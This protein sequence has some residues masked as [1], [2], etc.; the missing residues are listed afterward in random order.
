MFRNVES[1][2]SVDFLSNRESGGFFLIGDFRWMTWGWREQEKKSKEGMEREEVLEIVEVI[3]DGF[4]NENVKIWKNVVA[5]ICYMLDWKW[6]QFI[7]LNWKYPLFILL[8]K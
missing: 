5:K 3:S 4:E 1:R 6:I 7:R 2:P 8:V